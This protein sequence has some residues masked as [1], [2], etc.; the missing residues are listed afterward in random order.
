MRIRCVILLA[1]SLLFFGCK[2]GEYFQIEGTLDNAEG[3]M[4]YLEQTSLMG[5][6]V[7]DSVRVKS[8]GK[9][10]FRQRRPEYPDIYQLRLDGQRFVF[11]V[12]STEHIIVGL[13][14]DNM[15]VPQRLE[16]SEKTGRLAELRQSVLTNTLD[17]HRELQRSVVLSDPR[18]MV[19]YYALHQTRGGRYILNPY[20]DNDLPYFRSV[21]TA[22]NTFMPQYYRSKA[23]YKQVLAIINEEKAAANQ[24]KLQQMIEEADNAFLDISLPDENDQTQSLSQL[25]GK[26]ILLDFSAIEM[27]QS[28][29]YIFELRE[30]YNKYHSRGLE[31]YSVSVDRRKLLW[32]QSAENLPWTTVWCE[33]GVNDKVLLTYNVQALPTMFLIDKKGEIVGRYVDFGELKQK[34]ESNL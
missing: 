9:F 33:P 2:H 19:A 14:A 31:I 22:F 27:Q 8:S 16:G 3:E 29:G 11:V 6:I 17:E 18:S 15:V 26:L 32:Q 12:D 28:K 13:D 21:A 24:Q 7:L 20:D 5:N 23:L 25:R 34:I 1:A 10:S 4:L 30:L